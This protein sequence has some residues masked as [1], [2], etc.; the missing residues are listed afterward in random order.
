MTTRQPPRIAAWLLQRFVTIEQRESLVGDLFEE[1]QTGRTP[2]WYWR[3]TLAAL[4]VL[5]RRTAQVLRLSVVAFAVVGFG[6]GAVTWANTISHVHGGYSHPL[7]PAHG[8]RVRPD[9]P[10]AFRELHACP[11]GSSECRSP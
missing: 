5:S 4:L 10:H 9:V 6:A 3:E 8:S 2:G 7:R 11:T 1:Y